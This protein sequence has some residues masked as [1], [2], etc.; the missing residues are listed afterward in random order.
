MRDSFSSRYFAARPGDG[1]SA[2]VAKGA[3][4]NEI[5][6]GLGPNVRICAAAG[7]VLG[8]VLALWAVGG[9]AEN[10]GIVAATVVVFTILSGIFGMFV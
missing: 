4:M 1:V 2:R 7:S 9:G 8:L 5:K 10:I 6:F 3:A